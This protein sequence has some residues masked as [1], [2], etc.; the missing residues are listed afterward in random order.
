VVQFEVDGCLSQPQDSPSSHDDE[1]IDAMAGLGLSNQG[2]SASRPAEDIFGLKVHSEGNPD[3]PASSILEMTTTS[4]RI[5]W[6]DKYPQL[7]FSQTENHFTGHHSNGRFHEITK[8]TLNSPDFQ[9][10]HTRL[11]PGF[12][13]LEE[14]LSQ[15]QSLVIQHGKQERLSLIYNKPNLTVHRRLNKSNCLPLEAMAL[16]Q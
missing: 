13:Q 14:A 3:V 7:Y 9:G 5:H 6:N 1:L 15:I 10:V 2:T 4:N 16:F 12:K 11:Q 8:R